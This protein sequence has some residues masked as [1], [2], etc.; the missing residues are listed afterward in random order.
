MNTQKK[1][2]V[3]A[4]AAAFANPALAATKNWKCGSGSWATVSCWDSIGPPGPSDVVYIVNPLSANVPLTVQISIGQHFATNS[5]HIDAI[6]IKASLALFG[7]LSTQDEIIGEYGKGSLA[8]SS[9]KHTVENGLSLGRYAGSSGSYA[10]SGSGALSA[11]FGEY[12]GLWGAGSFAQSGGTNTVTNG[13]HLG[14]YTGGSGSYILSGTGTLVSDYEYV[15]YGGTGNFMQTGGTHTVS[16]SIYLGVMSGSGSSGTYTLSGGTLNAYA[17][18]KGNGSSTFKLDG[19]TLKLAA[20][21]L[22]RV[23]NF[24]IGNAAGSNGSF[25]QAAG[26]SV[27][28][29]NEVIGGYGSGRFTQSGNI[30]TVSNTL[31]LGQYSGSSGSYTLSNGTLNVKNITNGHGASTFNLDGGTLTL[32]AD[33]SIKVNKF[34]IGNAVG[35]NG[36]FVLAAGQSLIADIETIGVLGQGRLIQNGGSHNVG[37]LQI[38]GD[39]TL[40]GGT[41]TI[42]TRL[43][44]SAN[45]VLS[46]ATISGAGALNNQG[47]LQ[48]GGGASSVYVDV[49][50]RSAQAAAGTAPLVPAGQII[51]SGNSNAAFYGKVDVQSGA[52]LRVSTGSVATF[53]GDVQQRTGAKFTGAGSKRYEGSLSV[54]A[55]PGLGTDEG[56]VKFGDGFTYVAEIGGVTACTLA[57]E[58]NVTTIDSR[59]DKYSVAGSLSFQGTLML[60]SWNGFVAQAGQSFDL[61]DWGTST[62]EF[63]TINASGF[64]LAAGTRMDTSHLYSDGSISVTAVPEPE[65]YAMLLA[66]LGLVGWSVRR[67]ANRA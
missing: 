46:G 57:C 45:F 37:A 8:Q 64:K 16:N 9:G 40:A 18:Q 54:G 3:L 26:Q 58:S 28:S 29:D 51:L 42:G 22:I 53:F 2:L 43:D 61:F 50:N 32:A 48:F 52:E 1:I 21:G 39:Y 7:A 31:T 35:S 41:L 59:F 12:I 33:G 4:L 11:G 38:N 63:S 23:N 66:G 15:G 20:G 6:D 10:L 65:T 19:G 34:N 56:D 14:L 13:L 30:H 5:V 25:A 55:S 24:N 67:R 44:N 17:I 60:T 36:R 49:L 27:T 47:N 62:G